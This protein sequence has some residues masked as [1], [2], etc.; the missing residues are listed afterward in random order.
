MPQMRSVVKEI[1][2]S[3]PAPAPTLPAFAPLDQRGRLSDEIADRLLHSI[4]E[5]GLR[6]G[7]RLPSERELGE[8]FGVSR[9]VIREAVRS[10]GG[11]GVIESRRGAG[12]TVAAVP[13]SAVSS[14]MR[15]YLRSAHG[16]LA[17]EKV[18]VVRKAIEVEMAAIAAGRARPEDIVVLRELH[19]RMG[20]MLDRGEDVSQVDVEFHRQIARMTDNE[21]FIV[22]L[23]SIG[24]I[25][26]QVR[27][28]TWR[29]APLIR[30]ALEAHG[31]ILE[32]IANH[33][34]AG[35]RDAMLEHLEHGFRLWLDLTGGPAPADP[36]G[37]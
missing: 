35:A 27:E 6:P 13:A 9:T 32:A 7:D 20:T 33:D 2:I 11:R 24:D 17:Y 31:R 5:S 23:D 22:V 25:L 10:L 28:L 26:L 36:P 3:E 15:L 4:L 1:V 37:E 19:D 14:S 8:Q 21:L 18:H 29:T 16:D 12:L 34:A 30:S